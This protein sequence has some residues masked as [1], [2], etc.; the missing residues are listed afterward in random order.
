MPPSSGELWGHHLM[1]VSVVVDCL[2]P[3]GV[4]VPLRCPRDSPLE[5]IKVELWR[6]AQKYPLFHSLQEPSSYI[7]VSIT[8]DAEREEFYDESRRLCDLRLFQ[9]ILKVVEPA[10]NK[11]E[12]MLNYD[13][14]V[15][16]GLPVHELDDEMNKNSEVM[17]FRKNVLNVCKA[18]IE[19]RERDGKKSQVLYAYPPEVEDSPELP[20]SLEEKLKNADGVRGFLVISI[21]QLTP[22]C[23]KQKYTVAVSHTDTPLQVIKEAIY[24]SIRNSKEYRTDEAKKTVVEQFQNQYLLK[25]AG[26]DQYFLKSCPIS[27]YRYI[28][29][30]IAK[31]ETPHLMLMSKERIYSSIQAYDSHNALN[32]G[33]VRRHVTS[34]NAGK[35]TAHADSLWRLTRSFRV[36]VL[37]ATYVN[38]KDVDLIYVR[39]GMYHGTEPLCQVKETKQVDHTNPKWDEWVDLE[40]SVPDIPRSAKLCLSI[41]SVKKQRRSKDREEHTMLS[42]GNMN[43]FDYKQRLLVDKVSLNLWG[44]PKGLDELLYP[45]GNQGTNPNKDSPCLELEFEQNPNPIVFPDPA[46]IR[47]Y[48]VFISQMDTKTAPEIPSPSD[49][50][51]LKD[52]ETKDPLSE[53]SEQDKELL[54]TFRNYCKRMP[55]ILPRLLDAVK[56]QSRDEVSQ[57]YL[58][59]EDWR[60][61]STE[62]ALELLDCKYADLTVRRYAV[63]WLD[64]ALSD[65]EL[66][67]YLLQ[68]VQTLKYEQ[69]LDNP[70]SKLLLRRS[71]LNRKIGH[72]FFWHL[73]SEMSSPSHIV[74]FGLLLEAFCRGLGPHL[75]HLN[76]Q[77]D[78]LDKLTKLTDSIKERASEP[79][80]RRLRYLCDQIS[81]RDYMETLQNFK[82]PLEHTLM[83]GDL[84]VN[85][86]RVMDSAKKPLWLVWQNPDPLADKLRGHEQNAIIFKNGDD[87]RQDM[88]TLQVIRIMDRIWNREGMDLRM[89]PYACL[90]T[91]SQVGMIEVV[92]NATT[93]YQIQRGAGRLAA[94][95]VDHTQLFK[96]IREKNK[97]KLEQA[98]ETFTSSCAGYCVATFI[99]G[100]G[101]RHPDNIMVN[102]EGQIFHI[103]FGHFLGH[104]KKK[105]GINRERVP[106]VLPEDFI[107]VISNGKENPRKSAEFDRFQETC[108]KAYMALRK[109]ANL[110]I[111]LFTMMLPT[112]ITELQN[113]NDVEYLRKTLSVEKSEE[114]ALQYFQ[115]IFSEAHGGSWKTKLDWFFHASKHGV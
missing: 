106:F 12:K 4:I 40:I 69:Y 27:Q 72:F 85:L 31:K 77:V 59:L 61:V 56:W 21:W 114:E 112:G 2:L 26:S 52:I 35:D 60:P 83:L 32:P 15:A 36:H 97:Q 13:I 23:E 11:E 82:S 22:S 94:L 98:I 44:V 9:P 110:L 42:W 87:L 43:M 63:G 37:L 73:K 49:V 29:Q 7:F 103:D 20:K 50:A 46:T 102:E 99:L 115:N 24:K 95:Q 91:G 107:F 57:L 16:L 66:G 70:L 5:W 33:Y 18:A 92:R 53:I 75:K 51:V 25:V 47:T 88:L 90:A 1:P 68:L 39:V 86:C 28:R 67:Q 96:W 30:C 10:G 79:A 84:V 65:E 48:A 17:E 100:I 34:S 45:L 101:D 64:S 89:M 8:Q 104:Y 74:R 62:V 54:W 76:R 14:G 71:L 105:F 38:V 55:N 41:C 81:Q 113:I 6:E 111:T 19:E 80:E 108:G 109:H 3:N 78:A 93:V 58:L